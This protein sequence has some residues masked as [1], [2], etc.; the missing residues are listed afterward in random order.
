M[1]KVIEHT[2][3]RADAELL[4]FVLDEELCRLGECLLHFTDA[5]DATA[6]IEQTTL[7]D[8]ASHVMGLAGTT[9]APST[10]VASTVGPVERFKDLGRRD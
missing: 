2:E 5:D 9:T 6:G 10:E 3:R 1:F 7:N 4:D 8:S